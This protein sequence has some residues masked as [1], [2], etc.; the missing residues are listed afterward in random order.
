MARRP[1]SDRI[2]SFWPLQ[3]GGW[4][5]YTLAIVTTNAPRW[6]HRDLMAFRAS[7]LLCAFVESFVMYAIC[8]ALW[9]QKRW[10]LSSLLICTFASGILAFLSAA[11]PFWVELR[12]SAKPGFVTW[13]TVLSNVPSSAFVLIAW[14]ALYFGVQHYKLSES[15]SKR[16]VETERSARVAQLKALRYQL[17]PHFL[18][19]TLNA[20][21]SLVVTDN[22]KGATE[23]IS[24]LA[25]LL[26]SSLDAPD[27]H[28][29]PL[30]EEVRVAHEYLAIERLRFHDRLQVSFEIHPDT[31]EVPVP[32]F[33]LQPL[34]E[35]AVRHGISHLP[36]PG[37]IRL[38]SS[39]QG[40]HLRIS[41]RN[42]YD[43]VFA[44]AQKT[45]SGVG[46]ENTRT[47]INEIYGPDGSVATS[48]L[49]EGAFVVIIEVP[50]TFPTSFDLKNS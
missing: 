12:V 47:R 10:F 19:N 45:M 17:Q 14:A 31:S 20:V 9:R 37:A 30:S 44:A 7:F 40:P 42:D 3:A 34:L 11:I 27:T 50:L 24:R 13:Q 8:H 32:R 38:E 6:R 49:N 39:T 5:L 28:F 26:R 4:L 43:P 21:S 15:D 25:D 29:V 16:A 36:G 33:L 46:L 2:L 1:V 23:M 35:N 41:V 18:F 48:L 22:S